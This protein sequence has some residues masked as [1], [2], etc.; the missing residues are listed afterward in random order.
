ML[1]YRN[2]VDIRGLKVSR[3][4]WNASCWLRNVC[5]RFIPT[6]MTCP[7]WS[8]P[9]IGQ[10]WHFAISDH[11]EQWIFSWLLSN[12]YF[13]DSV[14]YRKIGLDWSHGM[15]NWK[16]LCTILEIHCKKQ[17]IIG[18]KRKAIIK[19]GLFTSYTGCP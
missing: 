8:S 4:T 10:L 9:F 3:L 19:I 7:F 11:C 12:T 14:C 16:I 17:Y 2:A 13:V 18:K 6:F 5:L 1:L 15:K